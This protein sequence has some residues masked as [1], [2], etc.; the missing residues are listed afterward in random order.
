PDAMLLMDK[1]DQRLP[2]PLD[3]IIEELVTIAMIALACLT[4]S[5]QSRPTMKQ[6]SKELT[7]F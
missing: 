7:G 4:E 6:V 1:L 3:P 2:H 5:P